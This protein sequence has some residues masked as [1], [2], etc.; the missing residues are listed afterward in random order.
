MHFYTTRG[1]PIAI[2]EVIKKITV[3]Q[4]I[5]FCK[6]FCHNNHQWKKKV[7]VFYSNV[8]HKIKVIKQANGRVNLIHSR[9]S[10]IRLVAKTRPTIHSSQS[11]M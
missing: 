1:A 8:H 6:T 10:F 7:V 3:E 5:F 4:R 9:R 2:Y 11:G